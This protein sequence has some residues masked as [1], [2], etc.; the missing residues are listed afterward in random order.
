MSMSETSSGLILSTQGTF[1]YV[2]L[3]SVGVSV[4]NRLILHITLYFLSNQMIQ[5]ISC[6]SCVIHDPIV[7]ICDE[8][9]F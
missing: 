7:I 9:P 8:H 5:R 1:S 6:Y 3:L 4:F 2:H